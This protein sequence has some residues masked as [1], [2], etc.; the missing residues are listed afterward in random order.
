MLGTEKE[1]IISDSCIALSTEVEGNVSTPDSIGKS[2]ELGP[3]VVDAKDSVVVNE[4]RSE[5]PRFGTA[6]C[7]ATLL[8]RAC[9][10]SNEDSVEAGNSIDVL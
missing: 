6:V 7:C 3:F 4:L 10:D 2:S 5:T 8:S 9:V 1:D